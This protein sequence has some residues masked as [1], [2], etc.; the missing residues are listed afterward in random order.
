M[1]KF[2][3]YIAIKAKTGL[4]FVNGAVTKGILK[5]PTSTWTEVGQASLSHHV[6][7]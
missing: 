3:I 5:Y 1:V 2:I 7:R 4:C 6:L